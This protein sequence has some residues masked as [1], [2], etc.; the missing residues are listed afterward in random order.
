M[1]SQRRP[2][3]P[4][5][6]RRLEKNAGQRR[7]PHELRRLMIDSAQELKRLRVAAGETPPRRRIDRRRRRTRPRRETP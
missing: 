5:L 6:I 4:T 7:W 2:P 1:R 3:T